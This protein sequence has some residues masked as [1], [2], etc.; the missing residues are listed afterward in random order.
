MLCWNIWHRSLNR[1]FYSGFRGECGRFYTL[2]SCHQVIVSLFQ[3]DIT[4]G[5]EALMQN[6]LCLA[7]AWCF[8]TRTDELA[9]PRRSDK[10]F[11]SLL[12]C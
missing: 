10:L 12:I 6:W 3:I 9:K 7:L 8:T 2:S 4:V 5:S 1:S 11:L